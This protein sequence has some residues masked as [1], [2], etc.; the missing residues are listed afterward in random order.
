MQSQ[1]LDNFPGLIVRGRDARFCE[2]AS[3]AKELPHPQRLSR[4]GAAR[5]QRNNRRVPGG[6]AREAGASG[7]LIVQ[8]GL[9]STRKEDPGAV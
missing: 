9:R 7:E 8:S 2:K 1:P 3:S 4:K 6:R 5:G